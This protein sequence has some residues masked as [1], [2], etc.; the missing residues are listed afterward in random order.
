MQYWSTGVL[1]WM[2][3]NKLCAF[4]QYS[5]T[6]ALHQPGAFVANEMI[7][8]VARKSRTVLLPI[9]FRIYWNRRDRHR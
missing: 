9:S 3:I 1:P 6:P 4:F 8:A 5:I 7:L 2:M